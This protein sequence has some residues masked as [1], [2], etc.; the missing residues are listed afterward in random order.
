MNKKEKLGEPQYLH[1]DFE[2]GVK[3]YFGS[4]VLIFIEKQ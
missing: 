1:E 3:S 4:L 2:V